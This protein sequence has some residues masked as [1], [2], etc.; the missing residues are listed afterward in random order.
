MAARKADD[1]ASKKF[2]K[3]A[4]SSAPAKKQRKGAGWPAPLAV[5]FVNGAFFAAFFAYY[6]FDLETKIKNLLT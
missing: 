4:A 2:D 6:K 5:L 1:T 3:A